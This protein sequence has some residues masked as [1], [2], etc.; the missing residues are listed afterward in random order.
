MELN[1]DFESLVIGNVV[2]SLVSFCNE[3]WVEYEVKNV[4]NI[5]EVLNK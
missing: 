5:N 1:L 3:A 4:D 2:P